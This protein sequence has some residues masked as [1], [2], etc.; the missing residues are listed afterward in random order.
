MVAINLELRYGYT[1]Y[2]G[3]VVGV[4]DITGNIMDGNAA[5]ASANIC[6]PLRL[7][8]LYR[9]RRKIVPW[10]LLVVVIADIVAIIVYMYVYTDDIGCCGWTNQHTNQR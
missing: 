6:F 1:T 2:D 8:L 4:V 7:V 10:V 5:V 3:T 9:R